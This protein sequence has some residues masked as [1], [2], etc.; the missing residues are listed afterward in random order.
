MEKKLELYKSDDVILQTLQLSKSFPGVVAVNKVDFKVYK[1]EIRGLIGPNGAGK[2]T[3]LH[4]LMAKEKPTSGKIFFNGHDISN[5]RINKVVNAGIGI[6]FQITNVFNEKTV[7][8]NL[9]LALMAKESLGLLLF[10]RKDRYFE[11]VESLAKNISLEKKLDYQVK[12]LSYGEKQWLELAM[13]L[14]LEPE[15][16]LLDEP[17]SGMSSEEA[18]KTADLILRIRKGRNIAFVIVEHDIEFIKKVADTLSVLH[19]GEIIVEGFPSEIE[20]N[21]KIKE[22][23]TGGIQP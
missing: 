22:I 8:E 10:S 21:Q 12:G 11:K 5:K 4:L 23:Y 13:V 16:I 19:Q 1:H 7:F 18:M 14:A 6:K 20:D 17:T 15:L 9:Q 3:F 2:S